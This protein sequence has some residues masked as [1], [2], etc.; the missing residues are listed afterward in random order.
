MIVSYEHKF[1]FVKTKKTAGSTLEKLLFPYLD[2]YDICSG[3]TR[4]NTPSL[5]IP[6]NTNGHISW[7]EIKGKYIH[8]THF[9]Q[10]DDYFKFTIE[11]NP[12]DK[13]VSAYY[14]HQKIKPQQFLGMDF[15]TYCLTC[16]LIP[17][18]TQLY[19]DT[20]NLM[21]SLMV[22]KVYKYE[23]MMKMYNDLNERFGFNI[24]EEEV[25]GTKLKSDIRKVR[26][27]HDIHTPKTRD[28]V[29]KKFSGTIKLLNYEY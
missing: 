5:G 12:W 24:T 2:D 8:P 16:P 26:D 15:E 23:D 27:Y 20:S 29:A 3:S 10:W 21:N 25:T 14:W 13:M 18:D 9:S 11:R 1:I 6:P 22:D 19:T 4:D 17:N 7:R 28:M